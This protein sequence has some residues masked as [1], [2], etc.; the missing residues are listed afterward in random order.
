MHSFGFVQRRVTLRNQYEAVLVNWDD[1]VFRM[2][3]SE[4]LFGALEQRL[5]R[6]AED[7][8]PRTGS[9]SARPGEGA[10]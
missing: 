9:Q 10:A 7:F 5:I 4:R 6:K 3:Q 2:E 1:W 8:P